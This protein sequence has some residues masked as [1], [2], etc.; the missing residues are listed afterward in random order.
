MWRLGRRSQGAQAS[1]FGRPL[2][3][4]FGGARGLARA[5]AWPVPAALESADLATDSGLDDCGSAAVPNPRLNELQAM[6]I[7]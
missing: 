6:L 5:G 2:L 7:R 3:V 4:A 1:G